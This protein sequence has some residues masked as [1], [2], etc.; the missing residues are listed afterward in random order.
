ML[1]RDTGYVGAV[2]AV[3]LGVVVL[4]A[5]VGAAIAIASMRSSD[6]GETGGIYVSLGDSIAAGS[7]ASDAETTSFAA[8]LADEEGASLRNLAESGATTQDVLDDQLGRALVLIETGQVTLVTISAGGNDLAALIPN[9]SCVADPLPDDCPLDAAIDAVSNNLRATLTY[10][11]DANTRVPIVL[12]AY[13]NLFSGTGHPFEAPA[14]RVLPQLAG[15]IRAVAAQYDY[16][17]VA[18]PAAAFDGAGGELTRVLEEPS[19][20]HPNDAG[21]RVLADAFQDALKDAR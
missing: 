21:H 2:I 7:G 13:P 11:R 19:D 8:L 20:P 12:L 18:D 6:D 16:V 5:F 10:I 9:Q 3:A 14:G 17:S 4:F 1:N 15:A